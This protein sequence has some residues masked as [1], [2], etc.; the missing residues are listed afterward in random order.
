MP[1][2]ILFRRAGTA[3]FYLAVVGVVALLAVRW[4]MNTAAE[5]LRRTAHQ[6]SGQSASQSTSPV[7]PVLA[8]LLAGDVEQST[9][10]AREDRAS[11]LDQRADRLG[12]TAGA[13][14]LVGLVLALLTPERNAANPGHRTG[15]VPAI[16]TSNSGSD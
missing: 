4:C 14:A 3:A 5:D 16:S 2:F 7:G 6:E 9:P 1:R 8:R 13:L 11:L 15:K 12:E 10:T